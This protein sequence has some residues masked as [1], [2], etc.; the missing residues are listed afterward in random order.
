[1]RNQDELTRQQYLAGLAALGATALSGCQATVP[2]LGGG[3]ETVEDFEGGLDGWHRNEGADMGSGIQEDVVRSGTQ[4]LELINVGARDGSF[5]SLPGDGL[6]AYP[7]LGDTISIWGR[8][9]G[10][11]RPTIGLCY[12]WQTE[13]SY[14]QSPGDGYAARIRYHEDTIELAKVR[15]GD[16]VDVAS[17]EIADGVSAGTWYRFRVSTGTDGNH[18]FALEDADGT[19]LGRTSLVDDEW[20]SGGYGVAYSGNNTDGESTYW[21]DLAISA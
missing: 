20:S 1:M 6:S 3:L 17:A 8:N 21:D 7:S 5:T 16:D 2:F 4:A 14:T 12:L 18:E 11:D 13:G 10:G 19:E 9:D 15:G